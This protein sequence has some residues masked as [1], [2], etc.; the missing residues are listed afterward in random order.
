MRS[1]G[2]SLLLWPVNA[3]DSAA[4]GACI[5][6]AWTWAFGGKIKAEETKKRR[7][8]LETF[9]AGFSAAPRKKDVIKEGKAMA[10]SM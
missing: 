4:A 2:D 9:I 8:S 7:R 6:K 10:R 5:G 1:A 3:L